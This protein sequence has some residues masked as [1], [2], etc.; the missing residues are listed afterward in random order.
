MEQKMKKG[1]NYNKLLNKPKNMEQRNSNLQEVHKI[2]DNLKINHWLYEGALLG[3]YRD[4]GFIPWDWDVDLLVFT[5]EVKTKI[6]K[7]CNKLIK[8]G[9]KVNFKEDKERIKIIVF[10]NEEKISINSYYLNKELMLRVRV[11]YR[12][13]CS[14]FNPGDNI[15]FKGVSYRCPGPIE[16]YLE[17]A[18][19]DWRTPIKSGNPDEYRRGRGKNSN[20][21]EKRY[22]ANKHKYNLAGKTDYQ[23][24]EKRKGDL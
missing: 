4:G 21:V 6:D 23:G 17:M 11:P 15:E 14:M 19:G 8:A 5:E 3:I 22:N 12:F 13:P 10:K 16:D 1:Y 9:C 7:I 20:A 18:Y 2:L 24:Y